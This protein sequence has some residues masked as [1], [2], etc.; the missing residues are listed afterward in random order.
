MKK[1]LL[2]G[3]LSLS[4]LF[5]SISINSQTPEVT[6]DGFYP[7]A[8]DRGNYSAND[9][10]QSPYDDFVIVG[11]SN[12]TTTNGYNKV[13]LMQVDWEGNEIDVTQTF[14]GENSEGIPW[15]H[16]AYDMIITP[17]PSYLLTG[18]RDTTL[19]GPASPPGLLL[20]EILRDGSVQFDSLY[21][22]NNQHWI[23]GRC[24]Q[25][26]IE[27]GYI[28][29]GSFA[30][31]GGG[32]EQSFVTRM[33]K[34][35]NGK[36]VFAD[37][38]DI[39]IIP[40]GVSG[41]AT[42]ISQFGDGYLLGGTANQG[43]DTKF[44]L[45]LQKLNADR[46]LDWTRFYGEGDSDEFADAAIYGNTVYLAGTKGVPV[47]GTEFFHD[48]I[49]VVKADASGNVIWEKTYGGVTRHLTNEITLT[50]DGNLLVAAAAYP[51]PSTGQMVLLKIDAVELDSLWMQDYGDF[52]SAGIRDMIWTTDF[53]YITAGRAS[54]TASQNPKVYVMKLDNSSE[55][56]FLEIPRE[57]LGLPITP[58]TPTQDAIVFT[59]AKDAIYGITVMIDT[60]LH[61]SVGDLEITLS[62]GGTTVTL[63]DQ[64]QR[65]GENF[66]Q[67]L[68]LDSVGRPLD[69]GWA[70]YSDWY[71]SEEPLS[72]FL[73]LDPSGE[74]ILTVLD[75]GT[76][77]VKATRVLEG[78]SLNFLVGSSGGG[79]DI[80]TEK[81]LMNF[82]LEQIR[83]NPVNQDA[84]LSFRLPA[85]G[86]ARLIIYNQVGQ[87]VDI[88]ADE[89]LPEGVHE[90]I[91]NPGSLAPG[92]YFIHLE[93]CGMVSVRKALVTR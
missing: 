86:H 19:T 81:A 25:P 57:G 54:L 22:N 29:A 16:G 40:V 5:L 17:Q 60:L 82:G 39:R 49:Y 11:N 63:V 52:Y 32:T 14:G 33:V 83:P 76:G 2:P 24:I 93:S 35:E 72:T 75:H 87:L 62:H 59:P 42:W 38:P 6:W 8:N 71:R 65:S 89:E 15:D 88:V 51:T 23:V 12:I 4:M 46:T 36:Y 74:W 68:L 85:P 10:K 18:F 90:R 7:S 61:P 47:T 31:D 56:E 55:T 78:W 79:V 20:M 69:W 44:D 26:A 77:G 80:P 43:T 27:G 37:T 3:L 91:W 30:E 9:I 84:V 66:I 1:I 48:Q 28:I 53:G 13:M 92:A 34:N 73:P 58:G 21:F 70:P 67:T 45:F 41:Y 64:P 50:G